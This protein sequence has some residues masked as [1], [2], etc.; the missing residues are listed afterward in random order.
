MANCKR[1]DAAMEGTT[2]RLSLQAIEVLGKREES[3]GQS[4]GEPQ[5]REGPLCDRCLAAWSA[6]IGREEIAR[7]ERAKH[8]SK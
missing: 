8:D 2:A 4:T 1:C 3:L 6:L 7:D 5:W